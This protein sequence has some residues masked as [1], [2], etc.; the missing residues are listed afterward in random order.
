M[1][2]VALLV[3][4]GVAAWLLLSR[5]PHAWTAAH[6][7]ANAS[8]IT[9]VGMVCI[10]AGHL[11]TVEMQRHE[12]IEHACSASVTFV[13]ILFALGSGAQ[14]LLTLAALR[15]HAALLVPKSDDARPMFRVPRTSC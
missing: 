3:L 12:G 6:S 14:A 2:G 10:G 9:S 8:L 13:C 11:L 15:V 7:G 4:N 1:P 5:S